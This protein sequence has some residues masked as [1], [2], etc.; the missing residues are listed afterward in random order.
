MNTIHTVKRG[1]YPVGGFTSPDRDGGHI[2]RVR[3]PYE[4]D[5]AT[6]LQVAGTA[7]VGFGIGFVDAD[8]WY[9]LGPGLPT[10]QGPHAY[11]YGH[12]TCIS[13]DGRGTGW[14]IQQARDAGLLIEAEIG[15]YLEFD[16]QLYE[17]DYYRRGHVDR[18]NIV[19][20]R[21]IG[22]MIR[23]I[24]ARV[25]EAAADSGLTE[26][27]VFHDI[28]AGFIEGDCPPADRAEL[29]RCLG[30]QLRI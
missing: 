13:A 22:A 15:D 2:E 11:A 16:G 6:R 8:L 9:N 4:P 19:L 20:T 18:H 24:E 7:G 27:E 1:T 23:E 30:V 3:L 14:E 21:T 17:I 12:A 29:A 28:A 10:A 26:D 5:K 25:R